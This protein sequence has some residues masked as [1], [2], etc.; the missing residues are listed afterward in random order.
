MLKKFFYNASLVNLKDRTMMP[1]KCNQQG[2]ALILAVFVM[3]VI[4]LFGAT[5]MRLLSTSGEA[6]AQEVLG[7]RALSAANSGIQGQLQKLFP[8]NN[9]APMVSCPVSPASPSSNSYNFSTIVGLTQCKAVV[10]CSNYVINNGVKYY[11]LTSIG[12]CGNLTTM[13]ANSKSVVVSSRTVQ[14]EARS[15]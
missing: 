13:V 7:S 4:M 3:V 5:M 11:R 14:V 1:S 12:T 6:V 10:S 15:L 2:S 9:A 8:L